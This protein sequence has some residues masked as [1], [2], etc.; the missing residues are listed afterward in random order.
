MCI[1]AHAL[2]T[3][4]L[5]NLQL[6]FYVT[7]TTATLQRTTA[8]KY[9]EWYTNNT[10]WDGK[11]CYSGSKCC[12][13]DRLPWFWRRLPLETTDGVEVRWCSA[14][15]IANDKVSTELLEIFIH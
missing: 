4:E 14:H 10:L 2:H 8:Q 12:N 1:T 15:G 11:D 7:T 5:N 3:R 9:I 13:D 6:T